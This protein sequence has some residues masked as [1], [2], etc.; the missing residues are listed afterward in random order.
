MAIEDADNLFTLNEVSQL[1]GLTARELKEY[2]NK[3][4]L[5]VRQVGR[6]EV[7]TQKEVLEFLVKIGIEPDW[8]KLR[9]PAQMSQRGLFSRMTGKHGLKIG[10]AL[11]WSVLIHGVLLTLLGIVIVLGGR[12]EV[13]R[14]VVFNLETTTALRDEDNTSSKTAPI[15]KKEKVHKVI[16]KK[17]Q[18]RKQTKTKK[19]E[20]LP[21]SEWV[22][23]EKELV[24]IVNQEIKANPIVADQELEKTREEVGP[25]LMT[26]KK[27]AE[28]TER[29]SANEYS[30]AVNGP[31]KESNSDTS[32][33]FK[34][35]KPGPYRPGMG[36]TS[37]KLIYKIRPQYPKK[38]LDAGVEGS[39]ELEIVVKADGTV[40]D[41]KVINLPKEGLDFEE[42]AVLAVQQWKFLPGRFQGKPVDVVA[43]VTVN[44]KMKE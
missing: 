23:P 41:V 12:S 4:S 13:S 19:V 24:P 43:I 8:E 7:L 36:V 18:P 29:R 22:E 5:R 31:K 10:G 17:P 26:E 6:E 34:A 16:K 11:G 14:F 40:G 27:P 28:D 32:A 35:A 2:V 3:G 30:E 38:A 39:V 37:P 20:A 33:G 1:T 25:F 42:A 9:R 44:F 21:V 15:K